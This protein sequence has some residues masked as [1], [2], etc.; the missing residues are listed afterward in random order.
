MDSF[1]HCMCLCFRY[2]LWRFTRVLNSVFLRSPGWDQLKIFVQFS[3]RFLYRCTPTNILC[4][5]IEKVNIVTLRKRHSLHSELCRGLYPRE[6]QRTNVMSAAFIEKNKINSFRAWWCL[7]AYIHRRERV[8]FNSDFRKWASFTE[9][10][11]KIWKKDY[12]HFSA[13]PCCSSTASSHV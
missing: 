1:E 4:P 13:L 9:L 10:K 2:G 12:L 5:K 11:K 6:R 7:Q 8:I 3:K